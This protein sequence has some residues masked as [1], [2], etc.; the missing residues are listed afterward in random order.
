[1]Q[2]DLVLTKCSKVDRRTN[3]LVLK[4]LKPMSKDIHVTAIAVTI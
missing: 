4:I 3:N 2:I 1:M